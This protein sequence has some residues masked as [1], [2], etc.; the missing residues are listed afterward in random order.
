MYF[1]RTGHTYARTR[2]AAGT[3]D[4]PVLP[5]QRL[6]NNTVKQ[7]ATEEPGVKETETRNKKQRRVFETWKDLCPKFNLRYQITVK[8][9]KKLSL[10]KIFQLDFTN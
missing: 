1:T 7:R 9:K 2:T 5:F 8:S 6:Q 10:E 4:E 3:D